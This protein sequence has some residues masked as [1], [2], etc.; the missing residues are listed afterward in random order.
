MNLLDLPPG[1]DDPVASLLGFHRRIEQQLGALV[2][3]AYALDADHADAHCA[4]TAASALQFFA[5]AIAIHHAD[6]EELLALLEMRSPHVSKRDGVRELRERLE[7]EHREMDRTWRGLR[8]PLEC[9]AEGLHRKLPADLVQ[10]FRA[11]QL[12]H[13]SLEEAGLR[14]AA[15]G[16]LLASD[17]ASLD[18][19]MQA[20]RTRSYRFQ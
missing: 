13:I 18:R 2:Q 7:S 12:T 4:A 19:G 3:L 20:R 14:F 9:V 17:R 5:G 15:S 6:E 11:C 16:R 8:R 1:F 10:Y